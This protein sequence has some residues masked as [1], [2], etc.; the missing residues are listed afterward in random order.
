MLCMCKRQNWEALARILLAT[1]MQA[2]NC[3]QLFESCMHC[4]S[5]VVWRSPTAFAFVQRLREEEEHVDDWL[6]NW[7]KYLRKSRGGESCA[8]LSSFLSKA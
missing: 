6:W 2:P 5:A 4:I 7:T 3:F 8:P 1:G